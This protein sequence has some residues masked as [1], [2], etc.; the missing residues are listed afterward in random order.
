MR[1]ENRVTL[2]DRD[3]SL[4][5]RIQE[6]SA[7]DLE[8]WLLKAAGL[9]A[10]AGEGQNAGSEKASAPGVAAASLGGAA[11]PAP[12]EDADPFR[13]AAVLAGNGLAVL[14]RLD[15]DRA[16]PL[17]DRLLECCFLVS[18]SGTERPCTPELVERTIQDVRTLFGLRLEALKTNLGF[19]WPERAERSGSPKNPPS[20]R[21]CGQ[22]A[23]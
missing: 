18:A 14:G 17:L 7:V 6:M 3:K 11:T 13:V 20:G 21:P 16:R 5:F 9:L 22:A 12:P 10:L 4:T 1:K 2:Q 23:P 19:L 8:A 15:Y